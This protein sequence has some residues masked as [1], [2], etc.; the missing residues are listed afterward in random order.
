MSHTRFAI[1]PGVLAAALGVAAI[2]GPAT[3][4]EKTRIFPTPPK[5]DKIEEI[6]KVDGPPPAKAS[7]TKIDGTKAEGTKAEGTK[8]DESPATPAKRAGSGEKILRV[9]LMEGSV[10]S[11]K[12]SVNSIMVETEFGKLEVPVSRIVSFTPGL[13]SH[14]KQRE[15]ISRL[16]LQLGANEKTLRDDAEKQLG[17]MGSSIRQFLEQYRDDKDTERR[18]RVNK[19]LEEIEQQSDDEEGGRQTPLIDEDTITTTSFTMVGRISPQSFQVQ[20]KF[21]PLT[22]NL[23]DIRRAEHESDEKPEIRKQIEVQGNNLVLRN[24]MNSGIKVN[25]GDKI[26]IEASGSV[27]M[28]PWGSESVSGP[29]G[30]PNY[31]QYRP[32][33]NGG[34][35][36]MR[37]GP[38]GNDELVGRSK[39]FT[40]TKSGT[41]YFAVAMQPNFAGGGYQ[42]PGSYK[43]KIKVNPQ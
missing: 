20:T 25:K 28:S 26:S 29:E 23:A 38:S 13:D 27:V 15:D 34:A 3:A 9:H 24:P 21:G 37:Y 36:C 2:S 14:P 11:G 35:L 10:V 1:V 31:G 16:V 39:T 17:A 42:F 32:G 40:A 19:I 41:L 12:L 30:S 18:N 4:Q 8:S 6:R 33:I 7:G 5:I 43:V 22:V